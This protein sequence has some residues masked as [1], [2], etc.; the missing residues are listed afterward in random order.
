[1]VNRVLQR[2]LSKECQS[3]ADS[4]VSSDSSMSVD[5]EP[6]SIVWKGNV[7]NLR[8]VSSIR[9]S[10]KACVMPPQDNEQSPVDDQ[11]PADEPD[12]SDGEPPPLCEDDSDSSDEDQAPQQT[13]LLAAKL[14]VTAEA[15]ERSLQQDRSDS[16]VASRDRHPAST[17]T[18]AT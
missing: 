2:D 14:P 15:Q 7:S 8:T 12:D 5:H 9:R 4:E 18:R 11:P 16:H 6:K 17:W 3:D 1:M 10:E 13:A